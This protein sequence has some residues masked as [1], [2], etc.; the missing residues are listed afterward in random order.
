MSERPRFIYQNSKM[1]GET[2]QRPDNSGRPQFSYDNRSSGE[3]FS[4]EFSIRRC[5][6][7]GCVRNIL[8]DAELKPLI[9]ES[10]IMREINRELPDGRRLGDSRSV[11]EAFARAEPRIAEILDKRGS[12]YAARREAFRLV[13]EAFIDGK[14]RYIANR[15][16]IPR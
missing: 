1:S 13:Q 2:P 5:S 14:T 11:I 12:T 9:E 7:M 6:E 4:D 8:N 15:G 3:K 16:P 10:G